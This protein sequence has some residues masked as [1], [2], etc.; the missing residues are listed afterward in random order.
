[1]SG[2][3]GGGRGRG[4]K[5]LV[6][7]YV[8]ARSIMN[9][10]LWLEATVDAVS[11]DLIGITE[12][13][14]NERVLEAELELAGY[15]L[16]RED[17]RG[18]VRGGG[19]LLYVKSVLR[20]V[21]FKTNSEGEHVCCRL[22][23]ENDNEL[24]IGV[25]YR[26]DNVQRL[27]RDTNESARQLIRE[28]QSRNFL[29]MGDF[30]YPDIDWDTNEGESPNAKMFLECLEDGFLTQHVREPTRGTACLDLVISKDPD[31]VEDI[32][33]QS[34]FAS[35]DHNLIK[36]SIVAP[37]ERIESKRPSLDYA[38]VNFDALREEVGRVQWG[39]Q[40]G[41]G[42]KRFGMTLSSECS[43]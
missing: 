9:K 31:L 33:I 8:N 7:M 27:Q 36:F 28:L 32:E 20:S 1:M 10:L 3:G 25:A 13:W 41:G 17:R 22:L 43:T 42:W 4:T 30:N 15:N 37:E 39:L 35:S 5:N 11:P 16:Y 12:S 24:V 2:I 29:I 19:V 18:G 34:R 14:G 40:G 21:Y 23:L 26:S 38:R 6:C